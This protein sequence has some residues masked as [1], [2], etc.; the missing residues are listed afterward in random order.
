M[1]TDNARYP[2]GEF[3]DDP[4]DEIEEPEE[5]VEETDEDDFETAEGQS[6]GIRAMQSAGLDSAES[7]DPVE[8]MGN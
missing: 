2:S 1:R 3:E 8:K 7:M 4:S 6:E 5:L